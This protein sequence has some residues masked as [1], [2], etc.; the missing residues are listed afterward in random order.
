MILLL[1]NISKY[2]LILYLYLKIL[3]EIKSIQ[4]T[5]TDTINIQIYTLY[6]LQY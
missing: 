4:Y 3:F 6:Q 1:D 2:Y 5:D